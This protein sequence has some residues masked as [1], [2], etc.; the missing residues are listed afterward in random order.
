MQ[1]MSDRHKRYKR[2]SLKACEAKKS[3]SQEGFDLEMV[4]FAD[5]FKLRSHAVKHLTNTIEFENVWKKV[6]PRS[7]P[8]LSDIISDLKALGCPFLEFGLENPPCHKCRSFDDCT[9]RVAVLEAAYVESVDRI[10]SQTGEL[11]RYAVSHSKRE[12]AVVFSALSDKRVIVKAVQMPD[13]IFNLLTCYAKTGLSLAHAVKNEITKIMKEAG[14]KSIQWYSRPNWGLDLEIKKKK[15]HTKKKKSNK[16]YRRA[17][18]GNWKQY[19][20]EIEDW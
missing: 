9:D 16:P 15:K 6:L 8:V 18:G 13:G 17:G 19:L 1:N 10:V 20:N 4:L 11:P 7:G 12:N 5:G 3:E 14:N 2:F